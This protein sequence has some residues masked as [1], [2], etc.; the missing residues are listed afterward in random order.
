LFFPSIPV[1]LMHKKCVQRTIC[2]HAPVVLGCISW[3]VVI[4][5]THA[6]V[7]PITNA[8]DMSCPDLMG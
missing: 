4:C 6:S 2:M 5:S 1:V 8:G 7:H 3:C